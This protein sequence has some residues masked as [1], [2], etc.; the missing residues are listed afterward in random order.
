MKKVT[1]IIVL[2]TLVGGVYGQQKIGN[3]PTSLNANAVLELESTNKGLLIPRLALTSTS[4]ASPLSAFVAGMM[5]YNTATA[6]DVTPGFYVSTGSSWSKIDNQAAT[7]LYGS[8]GSIPAS[9]ARTVGF[10]SGSS[11]NFDSNTLFIDG[12]NNRVGIGT[13]TPNNE[14][15]VNGSVRVTGTTNLRTTYLNS[16]NLFLRSDGN[17]GLVW[18]TTADGPRLYGFAGGLLGTQ[19]RTNALFWN[20]TG[21]VGLGNTGPT[22]RL[23]VTGNIKFSGAL[24]PNNLAGTAGQVLTSAGAGAAPTWTTPSSAT[25]IYNT[26]GSLSG[27]RTVTLGTNVL[28]F[29]SSPSNGTSHFTVDGT[30]LNVDAFTDR[31]GIGTAT[32]SQKLDVA[33]TARFDGGAL[34]QSFTNGT[35]INLPTTGPSGIGSGGPGVQAWI[36]YVQSNGQWFNDASA[37]DIAYRN[38]GGKLLW[39]NASSGAAMVLSSNNLGIGTL[40]PSEKLHVVGNIRSSSLAGTGSR[41]VVADV[42]GT[43]STAAIPTSTTYTGSTSVTLNGTSFE[44]AALTGDVTASANSNATTIANNAVTSAKISD[45]TIATADIADNAIT[46]NKLE[47]N[48]AIPGT[49]NMTLPGGTTAERPVTPSAGMI[50]YNSTLGKTEV[51]QGGAWVSLDATQTYTA[52][53]GLTMTSNNVKLGGTIT[54]ASTS[55]NLGTNK[56]NFVSSASTGS[57]HFEIDG[58]TLSI[59]AATNRVG[60]GTSTPSG[61]THSYTN[62]TTINH[63]VENVLSSNYAMSGY[64]ASAKE[65]R[66]GTGGATESTYGVANEFFILDATSNAMRLV[67]DVTGNVGIGN[68]SPAEKLHVTGNVR[69][70]SLAGTGSR[71]VVADANGTLSST[72][73]PGGITASNGLTVNGSDVKLGGTLTDATTTISMG[74]NKVDFT[75]AASSGAGHFNVDG[76]TFSIDAALNRVGVGTNTPQ[77]TMHVVGTGADVVKVDNTT[78]TTAVAGASN[79]SLV[80]T[81]NTVNNYAAISARNSALGFSSSIEFLNLNHNA[82]GSASG[83][84]R[85]VTNNAGSIAERMNLTSTGNL[86]IGTSSPNAPLQFANTTGRKL[87]LFEV[88]NNDNQIYGF[89]IDNNTLKYQ[90]ENTTASHVFYAGTS[91]TTSNELVRITG[92]GR[93]GVGTSG[94]NSTLSVNGRAQFGDNTITN[95]DSNDNIYIERNANFTQMHLYNTDLSNTDINAYISLNRTGTVNGSGNSTPGMN[96]WTSSAHPIRFSTNVLERMVITSGGNVGI[97]STAPSER[98]D[99]TGNVRFSG[100][101]MPNN[102]AGTAGQVLTSAGAGAAP[103]WTS[104]SILDIYSADGSLASNRIVTQGANT[105]AFTS[106]ASTGTSHFTVD[107]TTL[108]VDAN[109]NRV[110]IGTA[111]PANTLDVSGTLRVTGTTNLVTTYLNNNPL[112]LRNDLNHG[113]AYNGTAD[114]PRLFGWG[115]GILGTANGTN[116]LFWNLSGN[117][118]IGNTAPSEKLD[119]TGN[120]RFSGALMPNNTAGTAGQVLTSGG[121]GAA[122]TWTTIS[123]G[124]TYTGS[125]SVTLNGTSFERAALTGDVTAAANSNST[126]IANDAVT[127]AKMQNVSANNRLLGRATTGSGDIEEITLGTGLSFTGTTLNAA[128]AT[129]IYNGDGSLT[130]NRTVAQGTNTLAFTSTASTGTSHFTVDG[131][132]LNVDANTNRVGIGTSTPVAPLDVYHGSTNASFI[133]IAGVGGSGNTTGLHFSPWGV[134]PSAGA[135]IEGIDDGNGGAYLTFSTI[136]NGTAVA[137]ERMRINSSGN[138]A[139]GTTTATS[140]LTIEGGLQITG[141]QSI[142]TQGTHIQWNRDCCDGATSILNH[143]GGGGGGIKFGEINSTNVTTEWARFDGSGRFGVGNNNPQHPLHM[144]SG[145]HVTSAGTWTN[146]SDLRLKTNV[147]DSKYGLDEVLKLRSVDYEMKANGEKQVGFIA[148]EVKKVVPEVVSGDEN[149][150]TMMG[151]SYG[152]LVPVLVNAIKEQQAQIEEMKKEIEELKKNK[153]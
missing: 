71:M 83:S 13:T 145:A 57:G 41:M 112:Y 19:K 99:V 27:N 55:V 14:L 43:M 128:T 26:D 134:R 94:P 18:N 107:G 1:L 33:G 66:I 85:F 144:G 42:N 24:M 51:Y 25:N 122:P 86:G 29:T 130:G 69:V 113:V 3:N 120:V 61:V 34:I 111:T 47:N 75:S 23:D 68:T 132:T 5:V 102:A 123:A 15:D 109:N 105:L 98:L 77:M 36:G 63:L 30:T 150:E 97:G 110:G 72:A 138:I 142:A 149:S 148:Q 28:S 22:E 37:G 11:L 59:D 45:G 4:S 12:D 67:V 82:T 106:T 119:V 104:V 53:N 40:S 143:K 114:G 147:V 101:L 64:R 90:V 117:V 121:A 126:T 50:R 39:G 52:S 118:G 89:G 10:N 151:I 46:K 79:L 103:T 7:N 124:S 140:K 93:L 135:K 2:A 17:H 141:G 20:S 127:Y 62:S 74:S 136:N 9:T 31:V 84:I 137:A 131:T 48:I 91:A 78:T 153:K 81:N 96:I 58:P 139:I 108:N 133:R 8:N 88:A 152:N 80:N 115:G 54:D 60:F 70:S 49:A 38:T 92:T 125:T 129:T 21:N 65:F 95:N 16:N 146:A 87:V 6:G 32:P 35:W 44:R 76:T 73:I 56:F 116:A 100:A